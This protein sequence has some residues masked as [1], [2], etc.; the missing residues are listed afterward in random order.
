[1]AHSQQFWF[2][3]WLS[4]WAGVDLRSIRE[5]RDDHGYKDPAWDIAWAAWQE[6]TQLRQLQGKGGDQ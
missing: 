6:R 2:E 5:A 3:R 1:M 4:G